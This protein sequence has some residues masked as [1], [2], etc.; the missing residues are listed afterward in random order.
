[1]ID[2]ARFARSDLPASVGSAVARV[3]GQF[4]APSLGH[5]V[6]RGIRTVRR[7]MVPDIPKRRADAERFS[8]LLIQAPSSQFEQIDA[9]GVPAE[10]LTFSDV[11]PVRMLLH[12]HGGGYVVG[13]PRTHRA[14]VS[15][16]ARRI[17]ADAVIPDYRL[18][19]EHPF[20]AAVEDATAAYVSLLDEGVPPS[21]IVVSGDSAGGGLAASLLVNLRDKGHALPGAAVLLSPWT[22]LTLSSPSLYDPE[23]AD[24]ML[25]VEGASH[26]AA[27]YL[28]DTPPDHPLASPVFADLTGLP[29]LLIHVGDSEILI[30][31]AKRLARRADEAGVDV[32]LEVWRDQIHVFHALG[33]FS[34]IARQALDA[35]ADF[36]ERQVIVEPLPAEPLPA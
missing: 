32:K 15:R 26:A 30:D 8:K 22:D 18:A 12:L 4:G 35:I 2:F 34:P 9:G 7:D 10:R 16:L 21:R 13:S 1:M 28:A 31:D 17:S 14:L 24:P 19:P 36:A 23:I 29:P 27:A 5:V 3:G 6:W 25:H 20:P 33:P 11:E